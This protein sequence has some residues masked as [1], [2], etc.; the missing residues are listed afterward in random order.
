MCENAIIIHITNTIN[1]CIRTT[2]TTTYI[3]G[4][5]LITNHCPSIGIVSCLN[6]YGICSFQLKISWPQ[7]FWSICTNDAVNNIWFNCCVMLHPGCQDVAHSQHL[8]GKSQVHEHNIAQHYGSKGHIL[9]SLMT[10]WEALRK[11]Q[12]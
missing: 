6:F 4:N 11:K 10:D 1:I 12:Q 9:G 5:N 7:I 8:M 2:T 3:Y